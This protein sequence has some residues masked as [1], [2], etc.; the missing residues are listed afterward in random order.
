MKPKANQQPKGKK[1]QLKKKGKGDKKANN[2]VGEGKKEKIKSK[3]L[4]DLFMEDHP[5]HLFPQLVEV[6]KILAQ[7]HPAMLT[8]PFPHVKNKSQASTSSSKEGGSHGP[9]HLLVIPQSRMFTC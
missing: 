6:Q 5:T 1:K 8:N 7:Q 9:S 3:Y 4:C 2:N